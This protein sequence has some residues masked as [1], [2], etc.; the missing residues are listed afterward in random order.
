[1][2]IGVF[3]LEANGFLRQA[4]KVHCGAV[5]VKGGQ[6]KQFRPHQ[7]KE[8]LSY[9]D[10]FDVLIAHNGIGYDFPLLEKLYGW[11]FKGKIV[12]SLIMSRL[13]NPKRIVPFNC[14]NKK[15]GP[16]SIEAW[17]YRV[18]RGK[19]E[20]ND[21]ENFSE[22]MMHRCTEDTEI[23]ELVYDALIEE[24]KGGTW[25]NAFLLS[26]ELF[27]WLQ[28]QEE[29]GWL[30]DKNH[31][32]FCVH[33]LTKWIERIDRAITP[34][35]PLIIEIEETKKE[36]VYNYI[37][38]PFLKN[39]N[40]SQ[41]VLDWYDYTGINI[42]SQPVVGCFSRISFRHTNLNSNDE[43]KNFLLSI[44][45]EPLE[46]N[47]SDRGDRTSP[48]LSKD[49]PF[50]GIEGKLGKLVARRVQCRQRRS[51]IEGLLGLIREDGRISSVVN[52]LAVTGRAT[53]RNIV[54]I[55]KASS[56]YGKQMRAIFSSGDGF[57]LV[58]TDSA[59]N[60]LRQL[61][62]RMNNPVYTKALI[63]GKKEDGSDNHSLTRDIGELESRDIAKNVMYC[64]LFGGGDVKLAKTAKKPTGSGAD[65]RAKLYRGLDGLGTLMESLTKEWKE[66]AKQRFNA[67][68]NRMEYFDGIIT[69]LD[70]RP[71]KVPSEHQ[72]L[73]YLLQSDE[74]IHMSKAYCLLNQ[75]LSEKYQWGV[76]YGVVCFYHDEYTIE[77]K[78]EIAED[79]K[80]IS[81]EC[82][83]DAGEFYKI[84]CPHAGE[85]AI[86]KNWYSIH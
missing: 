74:A 64:L 47:T 42:N 8:L 69:G 84:S 23:L 34:R 80:R 33:Q 66:T 4:T 83:R 38:K 79:V 41:S 73:V 70:G 53:H 19:P 31:M 7:I 28:K 29:Y 63:E 68:F 30:V 40:Y 26:F 17:G 21:W 85:G 16:H 67:K 52:T 65:L 12:D 39:G 48:K 1:M 44:G 77:C 71:I 35:L 10:T 9:L 24:S 36:G 14:P 82:I 6:I 50:E 45:W 18:G 2:R 51:V 27:T 78:E 32:N 13:L 86:G 57:V 3:D 20:H 76:D 15:C 61:A 46:W 81:E 43:T 62:G 22:D 75:R 58:G 72:L 5:K 54:N 59:G 55:P 11:K 25:R 37:R 49:D 56:F 60:Q